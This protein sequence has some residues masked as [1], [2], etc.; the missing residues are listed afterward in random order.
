MKTKIRNGGKGVLACMLL[1]FGTVLLQA[2]QIFTLD[3]CL[4]I[5]RKNSLTLRVSAINIRSTE[6]AQD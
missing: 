5:A 6:F 4:A 3:D 2:Q 1:L